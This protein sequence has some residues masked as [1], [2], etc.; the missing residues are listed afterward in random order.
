MAVKF[1]KPQLE[2]INSRKGN[3]LVSAGA[4][5]GKTAVLT[6]RIKE[7]ISDGS[8][9]LDQL[10]VLTFTNKAAAEMKSRTRSKLPELSSEVECA[11]ITTYDAFFLKLVKKYAFKLGI[12]PDVKVAEEAFIRIKKREFID[13]ALS[14]RYEKME[15]DFAD[16]VKAFTLKDDECLVGYI[17]GVLRLADLSPNPNELFEDLKERIYEPKFIEEA[18]QEYYEKCNKD[19]RTAFY[20][21]EGDDD[22]LALDHKYVSSWINLGSYRELYKRLLAEKAAKEKKAKVIING[23][24][25]D[26]GFARPRKHDFTDEDKLHRDIAKD[27][28]KEVIG[29]LEINGDPDEQEKRIQETKKYA[30]ILVEIAKEVYDD[31]LSYKKEKNSYSFNDIASL[32]RTL[33][34]DEEILSEIKNKY[35]YIM[36]DEYQ[37]S[38]DLQ[39]FFISKISDKNVFM[40]GDIKQSIYRFRYANPDIFAGKL[41]DYEKDN[42]GHAI[43]LQKNFRSRLEVINAINSLFERIM[44]KDIG[45]VDYSKG[46]ALEFG[47][48]FLYGTAPRNEFKAKFLTYEDTKELERAEFEARAVANDIIDKVQSGFL[49]DSKSGGQRPCEWGDFAILMPTKGQFNVYKKVF[50]EAKIPLV[51]TIG[52][53]L[54]DDNLNMVFMRLLKLPLVVGVDEKAT[55]HCYASIK[56]SYLYEEDDDLLFDELQDGS[57]MNDSL[58]KEMVADKGKL[59]SMGLYKAISYLI[60]KYG[61]VEK[62]KKIGNVKANFKTIT[63]FLTDALY[64]ETMGLDYKGYVEHFEKIKEYGIDLEI[65]ADFAGDNVVKLMTIHASKGLEFPIVYCPNIVRKMNNDDAKGFYSVSKDFGLLMPKTR[66]DEY[67][68]NFLYS[69]YKDKETS[70]GVSEY[71]RLFYVELTRASNQIIFVSPIDSEDSYQTIEI[72]ELDRKLLVRS[73]TDSK[74]SIKN[75]V[76]VPQ[77]F[78]QFLWSAGKSFLSS[79]FDYRTALTSEPVPYAKSTEVESFKTPTMRSIDFPAE[80]LEEKRASKSSITPINEAAAQYGTHLHRLLELVSFKN[81]DASFIKSETER[82]KIEKLF[83]HFI[84]DDLSDYH[85]FHEY[86]FIDDENGLTG[87]IDLLLVKEGEKAMIIDYKTKSLDDEAYAKQLGLYKQYVERVFKLKAETYLLSISENVLKVV[88]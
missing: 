45:E 12:N 22:V 29:S 15:P 48:S 35:K 77:T 36:I 7:L 31:M 38:S 20:L 61:F 67:S 57:Y 10:L 80:M 37:D 83:G 66:S 85:E 11:D 27:V 6:E 81:K 55:K 82:T 32:A 65:K 26:T 23:V 46:Q 75:D 39:E 79:N 47:N 30:K 69:L 28:F 16:M 21:L 59:L 52:S 76:V 86:S 5:S 13:E 49:I 58:I 33:L 4:G 2:A 42:G 40:V 87:S 44:S 3:F 68:G 78:E 71:M 9:T 50:G 8:A 74:G 64:A 43:F 88:E 51:A 34:D 72:P 56:R 70:K 41:A 14:K 18:E 25:Y 62:L 84:F 1:D 19:L 24:E 60:E 53:E 73:K 17:D 63:S 54:G